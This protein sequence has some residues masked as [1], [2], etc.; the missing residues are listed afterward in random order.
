M[1]R[2]PANRIARPTISDIARLACVSKRTVSRFI[3]G[4]PR[5]R[6]EIQQ[7]I[8][9]IIHN[10]TFSPDPQARGLARNRSNLVGLLYDPSNEAYVFDAQA[11]ALR[12]L[13]PRGYELLVHSCDLRSGELLDEVHGLVRRQKLAGLLILSPVSESETLAVSLRSLPCAYVRISS[14]ALDEPAKLVRCM[15]R[16][17]VGEVAEHLV[18]LGHKQIA[19]ITGPQA[20]HSSQERL[21]GFTAAL[22]AHGLTLT[23]IRESE[24]A[25]D[26]GARIA[27]SLLSGESR[28]TAVFACNDEIAAG[29]YRAAYRLGLSI[30][31]DLSV[32]GFD[33]SPLAARLSPGLTTVRRPI[34]TMGRLAA[35]KLVAQISRTPAPRVTAVSAPLVVRSSTTTAPG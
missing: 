31:R 35:E 10:M 2:K 26:S 15:D 4:C 23:D 18:S 7:R 11:G 22:A 17:S 32:V 33:D 14:A 27:E 19:M 29:V 3:N 30:P 1:S 6:P 5:V 20:L 12:A 16:W 28:P 8:A 9:E 24:Y 13:H 21:S 34:N 25:S